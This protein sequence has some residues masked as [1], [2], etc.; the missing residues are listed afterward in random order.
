LSCLQY[1]E[2]ELLATREK[3]HSTSATVLWCYA[4]GFI[5]E[6]RADVQNMEALTGIRLAMIDAPSSPRTNIIDF[7]APFCGPTLRSTTFGVEYAFAPLFYAVDEGA[8]PIGAYCDTGKTSIAVKQVGVSTAIFCGSNKLSADLLH[9]VAR[10]AGVHLYSDSLEPC[11]ANEEFV[12][13]HSSQGGPKTITLKQPCDVIDVY[14]GKR[15]FEDVGQFTIDMPM[16]TTRL[17]FMGDGD[18]FMQFM[19]YPSL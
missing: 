10:T 18:R 16:E 6:G 9:G 1:D 12:Y 17:F 5:H 2:A 3:L 11:D 15:L 13:L 4:P 7:T 14:E 19:C 8:T